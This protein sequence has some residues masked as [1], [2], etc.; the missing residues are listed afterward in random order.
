MK[1]R[2]ISNVINHD[3]EYTV[4]MRRKPAMVD[5]LRILNSPN[6][7]KPQ[8]IEEMEKKWCIGWSQA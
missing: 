5:I 7:I 6:P 1:L 3:E 8:D 2:A 4:Q